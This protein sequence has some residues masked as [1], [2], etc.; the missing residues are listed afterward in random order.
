MYFGK[1]WDIMGQSCAIL[2]FEDVEMDTRNK[3]L[4]QGH[5]DA[6]DI[7]NSPLMC[8]EDCCL[9]LLDV[10]RIVADRSKTSDLED[11]M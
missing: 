1:T 11:P 2:F 7:Q 6:L 9:R 10:L 8:G 4:Q 5:A 3:I